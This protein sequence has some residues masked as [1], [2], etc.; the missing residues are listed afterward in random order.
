MEELGSLR[1][2]V[3]V[4]LFFAE[5]EASFRSA[6]TETVTSELLLLSTAALFHT[7]IVDVMLPVRWVSGREPLKFL[8]LWQAG[9]LFHSAVVVLFLGCVRCL[10]L[11][12]NYEVSVRAPPLHRQLRGSRNLLRAALWD[13]PPLHGVSH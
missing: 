10:A 8:S 6:A 9:G 4:C 2:A 5:Q 1:P 11:L 3:F 12:Q 13:V 7:L